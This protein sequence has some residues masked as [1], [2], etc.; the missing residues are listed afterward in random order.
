[1]DRREPPGARRPPGWTARAGR[2]VHHGQVVQ[3]ASHRFGMPTPGNF[4]ALLLAVRAHITI[5]GHR[6]GP[7]GQATS[8]NRAMCRLHQ[9]A[10]Q[11][12]GTGVEQ[13]NVHV[14]HSG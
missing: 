8:Q 4:L 6:P 7:V 12:A 3:N 1:M 2:P 5:A 13:Q 14:S 11:A 9:S 10:L